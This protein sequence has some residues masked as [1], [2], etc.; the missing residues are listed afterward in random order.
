MAERAQQTLQEVYGIGGDKIRLV[1]HGVPDLPLCDPNEHKGRFEVAGRPTILT[2]G[3][4]SPNKE[5]S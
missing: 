3:L 5:S 4:L 1:H 2:F